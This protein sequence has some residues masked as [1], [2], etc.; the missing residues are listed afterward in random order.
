M[1]HR[2]IISATFGCIQLMLMDCQTAAEVF[3][4]AFLPSSCG[5]LIN[6]D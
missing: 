2:P 3:H 1:Y 5:R 6:N 4:S